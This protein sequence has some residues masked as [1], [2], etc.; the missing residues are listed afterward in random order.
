[1]AQRHEALRTR[2]TVIDQ[3]PFQQVSENDAPPCALETIEP[4]ALEQI[5][6][7]EARRPFRLTEDWLARSRLFRLSAQEHVWSLTLH[8]IIAD[9]HS[10]GILLRE[11][12]D[13]YGAFLR[14]ENPRL[15]PAPLRIVDAPPPPRLTSGP[16]PRPD[17]AIGPQGH[18]GDW[19]SFLLPLDLA[20]GLRELARREQATLFMTLV[21]AFG[22]LFQRETGREEFVI[23]APVSQRDQPGAEEMVGLFVRTAPLPF[24]FQGD[25]NFLELL[26]RVKAQAIACFAQAGTADS[27]PPFETVFQLIES[28]DDALRLPGLEVAELPMRTGAAK[29]NL[30]VT[31]AS[32]GD[33]L[34]GNVEFARGAF[35]P[36]TVERWIARYVALLRGVLANPLRPVSEIPILSAE[37]RRLVVTEWNRTETKYP[38]EATIPQLF[39]EQARQSPD[40]TALLF[41]DQRMTYRELERRAHAVADTLRQHGVRPGDSVGIS[42]GRSPELI[43]GLL[44][45]LQAGAAYVPVDADYPAERVDYMLSDAGANVLIAPGGIEKRGT[46]SRTAEI[47]P[48]RAPAEMP[49]Y[50]IY[51]SGSTG[52]PKGVAVPH[53]AVARLVKETNYANFGPSEVFLQFAPVT[54]DASTFEIW[55]AL[56]NGAAPGD[57]S[58][59]LR[60]SLSQFGSVLRQYGVTTLWL[61]AG[62]FHQ[63]VENQIEAL[64][65]VRQLLA[66]GDVLAPSAVKTVLRGLPECRLINGY[67][68]TENTTFSCCHTFARDWAGVSAPIGRPISNTRVY[69]VDAKMNPTGIGTPGELCVAGD[70]LA[71]GYLNNPELTA[72]KFVPNPFSAEPDG[73]LYRTGDLARYRSDGT[74]EFLGRMDGQVKIRGFRV[75]LGEVEEGLRR[76][77]GVLEA[78]VVARE[79]ATQTKQLAAYVVARPGSDYRYRR[80][81]PFPAGTFARALGPVAVLHL[82]K[83]AAHSQRQGGPAPSA[84]GRRRRGERDHGAPHRDG[85]KTGGDLAGSA[86]RQPGRRGAGFFRAGRPLAPGDAHAEPDLRGLAR[87]GDFARDLCAANDCG[88]RGTH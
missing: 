56:L 20:S 11:F 54:F 40:A 47:G 21:A 15:G 35:D 51:T 16:R 31:L 10:L 23:G 17:G 9:N 34:R 30:T 86:R 3:T 64:S 62:L 52:R 63:M 53:R 83:I 27:S 14:G 65:G 45:I 37:E 57:F 81:A 33:G 77:P 1:M 29:F 79:D 88:P 71:L 42:L 43:A 60:V 44:G 73:R 25:P 32:T 74:I 19:L 18:E 70:G 69:I 72:A 12:S 48:P 67:G 55:G 2:L 39:A 61:T 80:I 41:D 8:H 28:A 49:A 46:A 58:V 50:V 85:A 82:D 38:R 22:A 87:D 7:E 76:H 26:S 68:P 36:E 75:E 66:G 78:A 4:A 5:L 59:A 13:C 24:K 6:A 84:P